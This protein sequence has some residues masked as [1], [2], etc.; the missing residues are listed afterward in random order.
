[1]KNLLKKLRNKY[2]ELQ[3]ASFKFEEFE[4]MTPIRLRVLFEG[5]VQKVGFRYE[6]EC[7]SKKLGVTGYA[8]NMPNGTVLAEL[9]GAL[10]KVDAILETMHSLKRAKVT[11]IKLQ[12]LVF[13]ENCTDFYTA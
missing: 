5:K 11:K 6:L 7:L 9:Q 3:V 12:S 1:M 8:K 2:V 13:D 10:S 4:D